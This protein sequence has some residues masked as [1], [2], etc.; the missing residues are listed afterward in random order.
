MPRVG[1]SHTSYSLLGTNALA[2]FSATSMKKKKK[3]VLTIGA[4]INVIKLYFF[5]HYVLMKT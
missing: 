2:Y 4:G 5:V 3:I 1:P